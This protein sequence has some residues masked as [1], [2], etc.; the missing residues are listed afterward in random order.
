MRALAF[1]PWNDA[2]ST[3][4]GYA[5]NVDC[6]LSLNSWCALLS[7]SVVNKTQSTLCACLAA[8]V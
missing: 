8:L 4:G 7:S 1:R 3:D 2:P 6:R 5:V